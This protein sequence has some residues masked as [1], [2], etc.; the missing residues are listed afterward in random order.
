MLWGI[1]EEDGDIDDGD[2]QSVVH[3]GDDDES[4][5]NKV[6]LMKV[7]MMNQCWLCGDG[8]GWCMFH[9]GGSILG[10]RESLCVDVRFGWLEKMII[11][12][13]VVWWGWM[14]S[15]LCEGSFDKGRFEWLW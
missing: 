15:A 4:V 12:G 3:E 10:K 9:G 2:E 5:L 8:W 11:Y 6:L 14:N 13:F 1:W 7:M